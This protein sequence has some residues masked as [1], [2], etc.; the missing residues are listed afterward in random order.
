MEWENAPLDWCSLVRSVC[1]GSG[2]ETAPALYNRRRQPG[3]ATR[4][5]C[6]QQSRLIT[7]RHLSGDRTRSKTNYIWLYRT[8]F[9]YYLLVGEP[10]HC[11]YRVWATT[12]R[13]LINGIIGPKH[14]GTSGYLPG[15]LSDI[16]GCYNYNYFVYCLEN[17]EK[18]LVRWDL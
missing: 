12:D 18:N 9:C 3:R 1:V 2:P 7:P 13:V 4:M 14:M 16:R 6:Y 15:H 11:R 5:R 8:S 10:G 17:H